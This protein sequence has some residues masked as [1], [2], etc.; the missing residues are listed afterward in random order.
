MRSAGD[1]DPVAAGSGAGPAEPGGPG[2]R[3]PRGGGTVEQAKEACLRLLAVRARSR[4]ELA[5]RLAEKGFRPEV[6]DAAL[7]RLAE[8]GLVDDAA[9]AEQWVHSRHTYSGRG[10]ATLRRE[11]RDKGIAPALAEEA[12]AAITDA[13]ERARAADLARRKLQSLSAGTD[14]DR[15][16]RRLVAVLA[17]RGFDQS[18]AFAVA[19][20]ELASAG[21]TRTIHREPPAHPAPSDDTVSPDDAAMT[22]TP[23]RRPAARRSSLDRRGPRDGDH[24]EAAVHSAAS[25]RP[26]GRRRSL[27]RP[28]L[29]DGDRDP[30]GTDSPRSG[31]LRRRSRP[32]AGDDTSGETRPESDPSARPPVRRFGR[33]VEVDDRPSARVEGPRR[34][35]W[36]GRGTRALDVEDDAGDGDPEEPA[37][38]PKE[39]ERGL[40]LIRRRIAA[41]GPA[42]DRSAAQRRLVPMLVRRGYSMSEAIAIVKAEL[43]ERDPGSA[44]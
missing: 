13:D 28:G 39:R 33:L 17:R 29:Q 27:D 16:L 36:T 20:E 26:G 15:A 10:R 6:T 7:V 2:A 3:G 35:G 21:F 43:A 30:A 38:D 12:L 42:E 25:R 8:V 24:E 14:Y 5:D 31:G 9:F 41:L 19:G 34:A 18:V 23:P 32:E 44:D 11:L 22:S 4:A 1:A 37:A 40:R